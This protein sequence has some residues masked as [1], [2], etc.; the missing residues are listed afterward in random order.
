MHDTVVDKVDALLNIP[1]SDI[2]IGAWK[3]Y[4]ILQKYCDPTPCGT[5]ESLLVPV[6]E[7][8]R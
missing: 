6:A 8:K 7:R 2:M 1:L 3:K 5:D 4:G